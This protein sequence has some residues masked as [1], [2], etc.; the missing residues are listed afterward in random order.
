MPARGRQV[1]A[2]G[3]PVIELRSP[4]LPKELLLGWGGP[5]LPRVSEA[6]QLN[7]LIYAPKPGAH[8]S[9]RGSC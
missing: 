8:G 1:G 6:L 3:A 2:V 7:K 9:E 5:L 4:I